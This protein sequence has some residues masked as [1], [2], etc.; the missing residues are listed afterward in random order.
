[1]D[2][3]FMNLENSRTFEYHVLV[4]KRTE[5]LDLRRGQKSVTL[6]NLS[7]YYTWRDSKNTYG[8]K[9]FKISAKT[10]SEKFKLPD[11]S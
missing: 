7:I 4:L 2:T 1:M 5:K 10:W 6:S 3:I 11:G 8:N 9:S